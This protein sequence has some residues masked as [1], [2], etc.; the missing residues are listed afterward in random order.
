MQTGDRLLFLLT[1]TGFPG[2]VTIDR[3]EPTKTC[4]SWRNPPWF[5][6]FLPIQQQCMDGR[7]Q[8]RPQFAVNLRVFRWTEQNKKPV[9]T[10]ETLS[11]K[12]KR[13]ITGP[14]WELCIHTIKAIESTCN[15]CYW[16]LL[17][18]SFSGLTHRPLSMPG[19]TTLPI[20]MDSLSS[21]SLS[22]CYID[23]SI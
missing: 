7:I 17:F 22:G 6:T 11:Y 5:T 4:Y 8:P 15:W 3:P 16:W 23:K 10:L 14:S 21:P 12:A 13:G 20:V 18:P 2:I 19:R 9:S 1:R